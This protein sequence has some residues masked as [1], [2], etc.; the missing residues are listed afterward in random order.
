MYVGIY[1]EAN[2]LSGLEQWQAAITQNLANTSTAGFKKTEFGFSSEPSLAAR[3]ATN[4]NP[5]AE[6]ANVI[7]QAGA[8]ISY[9]QGQLI[10][11]GNPTDLALKGKG[12]FVMEN[13]Q[14][15]TLYTRNGQFQ[16]NEQ[17]ELV[18]NNGYMVKA[19]NGG[20]RLTAGNGPMSVDRTGRV[21]Q[22]DIPVG[23]LSVVDFIN[24]DGLKRVSGGFKVDE[25]FGENVIDAENFE[26]HQGYF[27]GSNVSPMREMANLIT[28]NRAYEAHTNS[29]QKF[30][31]MLGRDIETF[32]A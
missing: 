3:Y 32:S 17:N 4:G 2:A 24:Y 11:S 22:N 6:A 27:E 30:D 12:F 8:N 7:L 5:G 15:D 28:V 10:E 14:G 21:F 18:S 1:Q 31:S 19:G 16:V 23:R 20:L 9:Q 25:N 29:I 26:I 13:E